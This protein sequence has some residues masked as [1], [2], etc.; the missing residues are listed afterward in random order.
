MMKM[1]GA[2]Q[3]SAGSARVKEAGV[4]RRG[5]AA[6]ARGGGTDECARAAGRRARPPR[7]VLMQPRVRGCGVQVRP[8]RRR[9]ALLAAARGALRHTLSRR[10]AGAATRFCRCRA[11]TADAAS[12]V[13]AV[14]TRYC[15]QGAVRGARRAARVIPQSV[16]RVPPRG[17]A[18]ASLAARRSFGGRRAPERAPAAAPQVRR[19]VV[20]RRRRRR[21]GRGRGRAAPR[22]AARRGRGLRLLRL[23]LRRRQPP[24]RLRAW[25]QRRDEAVR[26]GGLLPRRRGHALTQQR[27]QRQQVVARSALKQA[28]RMRAQ[29]PAAPRQPP[30]RA[31]CARG[32][33]RARCASAGCAGGAHVDGVLQAVVAAVRPQ[34]LLV[35]RARRRGHAAARPAAAHAARRTRLRRWRQVQERRAAVLPS[36]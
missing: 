21:C 28:L 35:R 9:S 13:G 6:R 18:S 25:R 20:R 33:R 34:R 23:L 5:R 15:F 7:R 30:H 26:H 24:R 1:G 12:A 29:R 36:R 14:A 11:A 8:V 32:A 27:Q 2:A 10:A 17:A 22:R 16:R 3:R 19:R 31:R 4:G